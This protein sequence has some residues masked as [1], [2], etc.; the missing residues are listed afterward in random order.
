LRGEE[1]SVLQRISYTNL[2]NQYRGLKH[3]TWLSGEV[4]EMSGKFF[5]M[6]A[7]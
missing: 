5:T 1:L 7:I 3:N 6:G 4:I 2:V